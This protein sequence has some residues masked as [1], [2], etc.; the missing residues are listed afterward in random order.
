ME[1]LIDIQSRKVLN[2]LNCSR[3]R[4]FFIDFCMGR[5][6]ICENIN[7]PVLTRTFSFYS[8]PRPW[9]DSFRLGSGN[10]ISC[11]PL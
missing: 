8:G 10:S 5:D 4:P 11:R 9:P 7:G 2:Y 1:F 3:A 6:I